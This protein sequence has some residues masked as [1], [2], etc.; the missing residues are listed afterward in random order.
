MHY[1][2]L[3]IE[4]DEIDKDSVYDADVAEDREVWGGFK[5][6]GDCV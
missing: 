5:L 6:V 2:K 3:E 1:L 4:N